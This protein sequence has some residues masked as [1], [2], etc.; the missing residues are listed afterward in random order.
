[1]N[2]NSESNKVNNMLNIN[3]IYFVVNFSYMEE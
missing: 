1:M 3:K 2:L